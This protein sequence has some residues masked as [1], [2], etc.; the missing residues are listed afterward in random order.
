MANAYAVCDAN[1]IEVN[2]TIICK[3]NF[4]VIYKQLSEK[5]RLILNTTVAAEA[6]FWPKLQK[7]QHF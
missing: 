7:L 3:L 6:N 5:L 1:T 4:V 2:Q